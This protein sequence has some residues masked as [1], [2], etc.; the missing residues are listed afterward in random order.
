[1]TSEF[2]VIV[3]GGGVMGTSAARWLANAGRSVLLLE[4]FEVGHARGSSGGPTRI[5]RLTYH[6]PDYVRMARRALD[7]WRALEAEAG[8][9]LLVTTA[10]L[11]L[12]RAGRTSAEATR[13]AGVAVEY[14]TPAAIR[15]R[16]PA[17]RVP[18]DVEVFVQED[19]GV[20]LA[21]RTV[22]AQ[23]RLAAEAGATVREHVPVER[24]VA[25]GT[26]AE[27]H[28]EGE[29]FRA[30]I[31]VVTAGPWAGGLL[32]TAGIDLPLT[33]SLEQVTYFRLDEP[34]ELPTL[35]DWG[36][37]PA[38]T[39]YVVPHPQD[40]GAFKVALH[41]SGPVVD[42]DTRSFEPD[43]GREARVIDYANAR[44]APHGDDGGT[45]TCL[46]TNS[47]DEDFVL[48]RRGPVV[49][50]SPCSGHGFKFAP[51]LGRVLA[52]LALARP[53]PL[54]IERFLSV[55]FS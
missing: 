29:S 12:G 42:A 4:R 43:P 34:A 18:E 20:C 1:M 27:V 3:V 53:A 48:D 28:A 7:E 25:T 17:L 16:W 6:H 23:A 49:I 10:G 32:R 31:V 11:D 52:D 33:P 55:R 46:Y 44:F 2:D 21:E 37:G 40:R 36:T 9:T 39:P 13:A 19:G 15:E 45:E 22:R 35:T 26:G 54:P 8:E 47:P 50:G 14:L 51:F 24:I 41:L 5:F 38:Q 30:P